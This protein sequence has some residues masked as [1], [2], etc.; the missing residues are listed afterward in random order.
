MPTEDRPQFSLTIIL[1]NDAMRTPEDVAD[2]LRR[3][4]DRVYTERGAIFDANGNR[5]GGF[6]GDFDVFEGDDR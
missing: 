3:T 6:A 2:A 1:G 4:A 5:V